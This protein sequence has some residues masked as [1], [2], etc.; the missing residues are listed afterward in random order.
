MVQ[1][2]DS[3][4]SVLLLLY[5][6]MQ[7]AHADLLLNNTSLIF[8]GKIICLYQGSININIVES[9]ESSRIIGT[10]IVPFP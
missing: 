2:K 9:M 1:N 3:Q 10:S 4:W 7:E 6:E 5:A 8:P